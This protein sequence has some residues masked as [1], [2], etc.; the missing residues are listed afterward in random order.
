MAHAMLQQVYIR[1][2]Q[3]VLRLLDRRSRTFD[4]EEGTD[5]EYETKETIVKSTPLNEKKTN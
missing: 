3:T 5:S 2:Y 1:F 4:H